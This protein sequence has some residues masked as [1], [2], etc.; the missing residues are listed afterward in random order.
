MDKSKILKKTKEL[1]LRLLKLSKKKRV[2]IKKYKLETASF[3]K[4]PNDP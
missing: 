1:S 2:N 3:P 4:L